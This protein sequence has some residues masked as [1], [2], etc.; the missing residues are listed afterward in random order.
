MKHLIVILIAISNVICYASDVASIEKIAAEIRI[1]QTSE[2]PSFVKFKEHQGPDLKNF[3]PWLENTF[4]LSPLIEFK[5]LKSEQDQLG[6]THHRYRQ[7]YNG[8][9]LDKTMLIV[10]EKNGVVES[11]NG[12]IFSDIKATKLPA[13]REEEALEEALKAIS[14]RKYKWESAHEEQLLKA[15]TDD[16]NATYYPKGELVIF[17]ENANFKNP[18]LK[19]AYK[20]V[21]EGLEPISKSE[22]YMDAITGKINF[23]HNKLHDADVVGTAV[24]GYSGTQNI[25]SDAIAAN[26]RLRESGRGKGI[27]TYNGSWGV[28]FTDDDNHWDNVN[29]DQD[30]YATDAHWAAEQ[31]YD[32]LLN[33]FG[34][35]SI[36]GNGMKLTSIVHAGDGNN[37][38]WNGF[39]ANFF[40]GESLQSTPWVPVDVV[41]HEFTHG[42]IDFSADLIYEDESGGLNESFCDI[43]GN[44]TEFTAKPNDAS[45]LV[46]EDIFGSGIRSMADPK[47]QDNPDT[48]GGTF[49]SFNEVHNWSGPQNHW[50]YLLAE[51]G[52]GTNDLGNSYTVNGIG[53]D[54]A[55]A[56]AFRNL[57]VYLTPSS[58]YEDARFY[59]IQ[60]TIDLYGSCG[61]PE[62]ESVTNA[63]YA[64]GVGVSGAATTQASFSSNLQEFCS[65]PTQVSFNN[66]SFLGETYSWNFGD[67]ATSTLQN[68]THTYQNFGKYTV[69]LIAKNNACGN[70]T[71]IL[72][73]YITIDSTLPCIA[74]IPS[75]NSVTVTSCGG[76]LYDSGGDDD[77]LPD[78]NGT[79]TIEPAGASKVLLVFEE[80]AFDRDGDQL[81]IYDGP[82]TSSPLI[83]SYDGFS[84]PENGSIFSSG[85]AI[86]LVESTNSW[87]QTPGFKAKWYCDLQP[88]EPI[89]NFIA[90]SILSCNGTIQFTDESWGVP[91]SWLWDFGDGDTSSLQNPKHTYTNEGKY[92][93]SLTI[94][95]N[96]GTDS[97]SIT[98]YIVVNSIICNQNLIPPFSHAET[99]NC[100][101]TLT[102]SGLDENYENNSNGTFSIVI[103]NATEIELSFSSFLFET[104]FDFLCIYDGPDINSPLIDCYT[105]GDLPDG[106]TITS[107][108]GALTLQQTSDN[109]TNLSGFVADWAC[110]QFIGTGYDENIDNKSVNLFPNPVK[111]TLNI[112]LEKN[113]ESSQFE[114]V[115]ILGSTIMTGSLNNTNAID[116]TSISNGIYVIKLSNPNGVY[117]QHKFVKQ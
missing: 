36:D 81:L 80:F 105:G 78:N 30:Q 110:E 20:F 10:H 99:N 114:I 116:L 52:S 45:Y 18:K 77:Y 41:A 91:S 54:K 31:Y 32:Y 72:V 76:I 46:A 25:T 2:V 16:P 101:G 82:N 26:F 8:I 1:S 98:S 37:A 6:Y 40:D 33:T 94:T 35:N 97:K 23:I 90:D 14:A 42:L 44:L 39:S 27:E 83:G 84:L 86:T 50:F 93:V 51:G 58:T 59:A 64:V 15:R 56:I 62:L 113:L 63:W 5:L 43:F 4:K 49:W 115:N 88:S 111:N 75:N 100:S 79:V 103:P 112:L 13:L 47:S 102:D 117:Y 73:D 38:F 65:A 74:Q 19:L 28:D 3:F 106:G 71:I 11:F 21:I 9:T 53:K 34:R 85:S 96:F 92:T 69:S 107:S 17:P 7:V 108:T 22:V 29:T 70:D 57:T 24:T 55:S 61:S 48:Y 95:N 12:N 68:P 109:S 66:Q 60:A 87:D 104:N 67:G 89:A